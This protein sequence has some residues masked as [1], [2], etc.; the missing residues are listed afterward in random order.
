MPSRLMRHLP[1]FPVSRHSL[2]FGT[3]ANDMPVALQLVAPM[4]ADRL[5]LNLGQR[6]EEDQRW[7]HRFP[8]AG[9]SI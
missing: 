4:G 2:P 8:V 5:L 3:D 6:L 7:Q 1:I 9:L